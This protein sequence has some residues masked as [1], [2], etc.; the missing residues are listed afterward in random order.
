MN[1]HG[2]LLP[3]YRGASPL[4]TVFLEKEKET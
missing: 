4:Q 2:S 3:K 1:I